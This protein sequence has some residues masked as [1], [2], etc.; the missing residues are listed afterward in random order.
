MNP[1]WQAFL[2][3]RQ[4]VIKDGRT[5]HFGNAAAEL[6][7]TKDGTVI[8]DLSHLGLIQFSGEDAQAFLQGQLTCDVIKIKPDMAQY[9]GYCTPKGRLL[10]NFLLWQNEGYLMQLPAGLCAAIQQRL[11]LFVLRAKVKLTN[12]NDKFIRIGVA[13]KNARMIVEKVSGVKFGPDQRLAV[14]HN[15]QTSIICLAPHRFE[16]IA[17]IEHAPTL[18]A[19]LTENTTPAGAI[20]WDWL[21]IQ[22]G[23]PVILPATQEEFIPQMVNLDAIDGV[24]FQKGC[25]PGQEIVA[26]TR[27]LG[28]LKRRMYLAHIATDTPV[29]PG[30]DLFSSS[31]AEQSCGNIVNAAPA[32][33]G[34][35]D[36][37]AVIQISSA[38]VDT[39]HWKAK[40]GT[41]LG[42]GPQPYLLSSE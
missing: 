9:G 22:S 19:H 20:C 14:Q 35:Y 26:R 40:N 32:P 15:E 27:Y 10:A 29:A 17:A 24:S 6:N 28:K 3:S 7:H 21:D 36:V 5:L 18:W 13:G 34:G 1:S 8:V 2:Q 41:V 4:A 11:S 30:D 23:I 42:I 37:L 31:T 39:V 25:Y 33:D 16:F 38:E 12:I